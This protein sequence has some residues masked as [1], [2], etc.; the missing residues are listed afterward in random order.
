MENAGGNRRSRK[1]GRQ[2]WFR[3][4]LPF[5]RDGHT[6]YLSHQRS[7]SRRTQPHVHLT[8]ASFGNRVPPFNP[9]RI[10]GCSSYSEPIAFPQP[11]IYLRQFNSILHHLI[12]GS[13]SISH[14]LLPAEQHGLFSFQNGLD[15][16]S[17]LC[18]DRDGCTVSRPAL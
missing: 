3:R 12:A 9:D 17:Q 10:A 14:A 6:S 11:V 4:S 16:Y 8:P 1:G 18:R 13:D 15:H 2:D 5:A 7:A